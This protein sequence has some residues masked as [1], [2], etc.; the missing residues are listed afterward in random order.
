MARKRRARRGVPSGGPPRARLGRP[1]GDPD[2]GPGRGG[3]P[4]PTAREDTG[5]ARPFLAG[6]IC[7]TLPM[8][9]VLLLRPFLAD[10]SVV[11]FALLMLSIVP[12]AFIALMV[13][14]TRVSLGIAGL[15]LM[16][17]APWPV[18]FGLELRT[19]GTIPR[20]TMAEVSTRGLAAG[21]WLADAVPRP[22]LA[23]RASF[24][25]IDWTRPLPRRS[26]A[27]TG[28]TRLAVMPVTDPG[29]TPE[30]IVRVAAVQEMTGWPER[31]VAFPAP[32]AEAG[33]LVMLLPDDRLE[34]RVRAMLRD[35]GLAAS[36]HLLIGRWSEDPVVTWWEGARFVLQLWGG[37]VAAWG[38]LLLLGWPRAR[39]QG[40][41][42][43]P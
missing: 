25:T 18:A 3:L 4:A 28:P 34:R 11:L 2:G 42:G 10:G 15:V 22:D 17:L 20:A 30:Q 32:W 14:P 35:G 31:D 24:E 5:L 16:I 8:A 43:M 9:I 41:W 21:Y 7:L 1:P 38:L 12:G 40:N 19:F 23:R 36:P 29:W 6:V 27:V 39:A 26:G 33:G 37:C 13:Y